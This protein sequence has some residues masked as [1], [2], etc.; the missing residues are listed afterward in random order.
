[1]DNVK[2]DEDKE[3]LINAPPHNKLDAVQ[4]RFHT[5]TNGFTTVSQYDGSTGNNDATPISRYDAAPTDDATTISQC[6]AT[7]TMARVPPNELWVGI[8][9]NA[10]FTGCNVSW[11]EYMWP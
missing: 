3:E 9:S 7:D 6:N 4:R 2:D 1:M 11:S 8:W 10:A 5:S